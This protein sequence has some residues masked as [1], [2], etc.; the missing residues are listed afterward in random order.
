MDK[1]LLRKVQ[2]LELMILEEVDRICKKYDLSYVLG[3]GTLIGAVRHSGFIPWDDDVDIFMPRADYEKFLEVCPKELDE[4]FLLHY[5][6]T[7]K[8][9][10]IAITKVR[11][12]DTVFLQ[13]ADNREMIS[14]GIWIDVFC[15]DKAKKKTSFSQ[16]AKFSLVGAINTVKSIRQGW[17]PLKGSSLSIKLF[18]WMLRPFTV[19]ALYRMQECIKKGC[20]KKKA[21][22]LV[23]YSGCYGQIK[24]TFSEKDLFP[25]QRI[26][27]EGKDFCVP[28]NYHNVLCQIYGES[29]MTPPPVE[30]RVTHNPIRVDLGPYAEKSEESE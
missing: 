24:Q 1:E 16:R 8:N 6:K 27:F 19:N 4:K 30:K 2:L 21:E 28:N 11:L 22:Y 29:Y 25:P 5:L 13:R 20:S 23:E 26:P 17:N 7:D 14:E 18:Y 12:K 10:P 15:L 9:Y 3:Y